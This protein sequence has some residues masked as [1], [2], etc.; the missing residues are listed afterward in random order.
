[1]G[2]AGTLAKVVVQ[3]EYM[4]ASGPLEYTSCCTAMLAHTSKLTEGPQPAIIFTSSVL[5]Y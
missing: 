3:G 2:S 1:M 4:A 5:I